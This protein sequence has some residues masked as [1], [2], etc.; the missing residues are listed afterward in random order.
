MAGEVNGLRWCSV[1]VA[2][3]LWRK[4]YIHVQVFCWGRRET[5]GL[6]VALADASDV[7]R[8]VSVVST[9]A[10]RGPYK[11]RRAATLQYAMHSLQMK[12][13]CESTFASGIT[14]GRS[15]KVPND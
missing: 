4:R 11:V 3:G 1:R 2:W 7:V 6:Q 14:R 13:T 10:A 15:Q 12:V 5:H 9:C 8:G